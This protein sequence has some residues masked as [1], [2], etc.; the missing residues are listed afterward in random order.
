[1]LKGNTLKLSLLETMVGFGVCF[2]QLFFFFNILS[3]CI[4]QTTS[5]IRP[6]ILFLVVY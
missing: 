2:L 1:M 5:S 3:V 6:R 4:A